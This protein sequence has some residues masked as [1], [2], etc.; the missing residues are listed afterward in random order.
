MRI[1]RLELYG[2]TRLM[3]NNIQHF[4]YTPER[5]YQLILGTN[6][7]GKSSILFELSPLPA[8]QSFY[9]KEGHKKVTITHRGHEYVLTSTFKNG[10]KHSFLKNGE[11]LNP[12]QTGQ[13]QKELCKIE[14]GYTAELHALL[15]GEERFTH[16]APMRRREWITQLSSEDYTFA[17]GLYNRLRSA[18]RDRQ[19]AAKHLK[20]RITQETNNLRAL[21]DVTGLEERAALLREELTLLL[22]SRRPDLP[23]LHVI[24][25]QLSQLTQ[26]IESTSRQILQTRAAMHARGARSLDHLNS[27][28]NEHNAELQTRTALLNRSTTEYSEL[29]SMVGSIGLEPEAVPENLDGLILEREQQIADLRSKLELFTGLQD[30]PAILRDSRFLLD[31]VVEL[32][33]QLP[34]N[35]DRR[36]SAQAVEESKARRRSM[37]ETIDKSNIA[38]SQ[39]RRK[40]AHIEEAKDTSCP[41][42]KYVWR[43]GYSEEELAQLR[44]WQQDHID[45]ITAMEQKI[46]EE[47]TY[48]EQAQDYAALYTRFRGMVDGY[49]R[50][51]PLWDYILQSGMLL[52]NPSQQVGLFLMWQRDVE[53]SAEIHELEQNLQRLQ[54][55]VTRQQQYGGISQLQQRLFTLRDEIESSTQ[56]VLE[57]QQVQKDLTQS[58]DVMTRMMQGGQRLEEAGQRYEKLSQDAIEALRN[59]HIDKLVEGHHNELAL[60]QRRLMDKNSLEGIV[61]DLERS[62][63]DVELDYQA[64]LAMAEELSP[65]DGLIAEQLSGFIGCLVAQFNSII[66]TVW[67]KD[68]KVEPCGL[69]SGELNYKFPLHSGTSPRPVP[70]VSKGSKAQQALVDFAFVL[71]VMLYMGLQDFP[72]FLDEPGEGFDEQHRVNLMAFIKQLMDVNQYPQLFMISH[73]ASNHGAFT[74]A[75]VMV[76]DSS[77]I[78]VPSEYNQHVVLA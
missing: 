3:L 68:L 39:I 53:R 70:D 38:L 63:E 46:A 27:M 57:Y 58:R 67:T 69:E 14:F 32:F 33:G 48:L 74:T 24:Q 1:E 29:E 8:H 35:G 17:L 16:M 5:T 49:P 75:E 19:G 62:H 50:M 77:N 20:Q 55:L 40:I 25:N 45:V 54:E 73:Y 43:E 26:E 21:E 42:C 18:A 37:Q 60:I 71:T 28:L 36:W 76:L 12:G 44:Q 51:K 13:V 9:T 41:K 11:E 4:V 31:Q 7:S 15:T 59:E 30:A 23:Q 2:Y 52:N 64:L 10:N 72:L 66:A 56:Q 22:S 34:D 65:T 47:N 61:R 6:G 78:A